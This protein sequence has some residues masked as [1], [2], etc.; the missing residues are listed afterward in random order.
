VGY[1]PMYNERKAYIVL[2]NATNT[3]IYPL[4]SDPRTWLPNGVVTVI[5]DT[6]QLYYDL[7]IGTYDVCLWLPDMGETIQSDSR[8]AIRLANKDVWEETTGYNVLT[9]ITL[10]TTG[11]TSQFTDSPT[12]PFTKI[13]KDGHLYIQT[14]HNLYTLLGQLL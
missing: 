2:R 5:N 10:S 9:S 1:A 7:Q 14:D 3:Y 4:H 8:F 13:L 11:L 12:H 6:I